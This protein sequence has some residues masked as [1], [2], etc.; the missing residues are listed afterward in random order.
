M[1]GRFTSRM[2]GQADADA[3]DTK[4]EEPGLVRA[5]APQSRTGLRCQSY[6]MRRIINVHGGAPSGVEANMLIPEQAAH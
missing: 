5:D 6:P 2:V 3:R 4:G 1:C